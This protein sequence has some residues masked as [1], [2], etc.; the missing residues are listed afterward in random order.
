MPE[1]RKIIIPEDLQEFL[2]VNADVV[3]SK[4]QEVVDRRAA[5]T[6]EEIFQETSIAK[7][8]LELFT[9][10]EMCAMF[11]HAASNAGFLEYKIME[12]LDKAN[13]PLPLFRAIMAL[14]LP[15]QEKV[16]NAYRKTDDDPVEPEDEDFI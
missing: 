2:N 1:S 7:D 4:M 6:D 14:E 8:Y 11:M 12:L 13:I 9:K 15:D 16:A 5:A 10:E 3:N